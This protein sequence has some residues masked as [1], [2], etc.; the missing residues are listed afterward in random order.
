VHS[1]IAS[2]KSHI[3]VGVTEVIDSEIV[4]PIVVTRAVIDAL[5]NNTVNANAAHPPPFGMYM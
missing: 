2:I 1:N 4:Y 3:S 5:I